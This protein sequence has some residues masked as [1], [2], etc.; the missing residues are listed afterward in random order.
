MMTID[1]ESTGL[2]RFKDEI[3]LIGV[4]REDKKQKIYTPDKFYQFV[5]EAKE[6][7]ASGEHFN[8]QNGKFD[9]LFIDHKLKVRLPINDD[10]LL[11]G[12]A[13]ALA[14]EHNLKKMAMNYLGVPNWEIGTAK[15]KNPNSPELIP[16]LRKD[17]RYTRELRD[18]FYDEMTPEQMKIYREL[19]R[20]A[21]RAY[22]TIE[23]H[24][25]FL[26]QNGLD[27]V[28]AR[29]KI[30]AER[31]L[32]RLKA[33]YDINWNAPGQVADI[34]YNKLGLPV[35]KRT[36]KGAPS[37]TAPILRRFATSENIG[38]SLCALLLE[39]KDYYGAISKFF[40]A[41][42]DYSKTDGRIHPH[43]NLTNVVTGRTSCSDP[44]LQQVPRR[45]ELRT[46]FVAPKGRVLIEADY[47]QLEL[48][49]AADYANERT[50]IKI[51]NS[52][53]GDI[54]ME[55]GRI[56][57][58]RKEITKEE[59]S[60]AKPVNFGFLYG[61]GYK[62]FVDYA[63]NS[64]GVK[65][66]ESEAK[67]FRELYFL[68]YPR[69][70]KWHEEQE[71]LCKQQGG[72]YTRFGRFRALPDI[73]SKDH[74]LQ[75]G[76]KRRAINTP[77]QSTGSD[78]ILLSVTELEK[79]LKELD[80]F[81]VV[82]VHDSILVEAPEKNVEAVVRLIK[83]VMENPKGLQTFGVTFRVP[84]IADIKVGPWGC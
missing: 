6:W 23:S 72:V 82:T 52:T 1:I 3:I 39:Y 51:Y 63:L 58:G 29:Y 17:L 41:W 74:K 19:L 80:A 48:R 77:V 65:V 31:L 15:K 37:A 44:N 9:T 24:G 18:Y 28:A 61:M 62:G 12:T 25:I 47:S 53:D 56:I 14:D 70:L 50:M 22:R 54:H 27:A 84:I 46:L 81:V 75:S 32:K 55:T 60:R 13:Y 73:Y 79:P 8:W 43:F 34:L 59:R 4:E 5:G 7:K 83:A 10:T 2:N 49:I 45:K 69:L 33:E 57:T 21:Y 35:L 66:T 30:E 78:L 42:K 20:P 67:K 76:A 11:L 16:Y 71:E 40:G 68:K 38:S 36:E 26:D 64:Y